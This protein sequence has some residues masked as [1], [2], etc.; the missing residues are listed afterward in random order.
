MFTYGIYDI[1]ICIN[2]TP[3]LFINLVACKINVSSVYYGSSV[4]GEKPPGEKTPG[5][6]LG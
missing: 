3:Q 6:K 2:M 4:T 5:K 1:Y